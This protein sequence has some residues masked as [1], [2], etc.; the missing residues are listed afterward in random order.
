MLQPLWWRPG[1]VMLGLGFLALAAGETIQ[2][3]EWWVPGSFIIVSGLV[4]LPEIRLALQRGAEQILA[5]HLLALAGAFIMYF[6]I[7]ALLIPFGSRDQTEYTL[8]YYW[9]DAPLG[10][11][12]TAVN[13][14]GFG[15]ALVSGSLVRRH[16]V[17]RWARTAIGF[18]RSIPLEWVIAAFLI[19]G[20]ASS[21]YLLPFDIGLRPGVEFGLFRTTS[22]LLLVAI[23]VAA[24]HRG[25]GSVGL[26][27]VAI[28]LTVVQTFGGLLMLN[29]SAVLLPI[30]ALLAGLAWRLGVRRVMIPGLVVLLA[31]FKLI[32]DPVT[33]ARNISG[34]DNRINWSERIS[35]L[36]EGLLSSTPATFGGDFYVWNRFSYL[37]S[38]GAAIDF[39]DTG[40]GGDDYS[41]LGWAFLPRFLFPDKPLISSTGRE[42]NI[43]ITGSDTSS[44]APGVFA[45]GYYNF[46]LWGVML[47]GIAVGCM[48][49]WTSTFAAEVY[50]ARALIWLPMALLG[51]FMAFR[52]DGNFL[53]DYWGSFV[54]LGYA[55]FF[56]AVMKTLLTRD[57]HAS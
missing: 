52:V 31:V 41:R 48:L 32:G 53:G 43:K 28:L 49:A 56:G 14:I 42:F 22:K 9:V 34:L 44:N 55:V 38:Q 10:M 37:S 35:V 51:S 21:L 33:T 11:H 26:L 12:A 47:V 29:K 46:G 54:L 5:D 13:C 20:G 7:G 40:R 2:A 4:L 3:D 50:R 6:V 18:G 39:Y 1:V 19:V 30:T 25:R 23:M 17:S 57:K 45:D 15:L 27:S 8:S 16:W 24:A 36:S